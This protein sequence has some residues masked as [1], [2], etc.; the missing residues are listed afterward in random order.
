MSAIILLR[1]NLNQ[2]DA[3]VVVHKIDNFKFILENSN[4]KNRLNEVEVLCS[5]REN[6]TII[7]IRPKSLHVEIAN[8]EPRIGL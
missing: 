4:L 1:D 8:N 2:R 5:H 3:A 7:G 6:L